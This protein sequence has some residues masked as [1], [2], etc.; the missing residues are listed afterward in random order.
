MSIPYE[1]IILGFKVN[2]HL[3]CEYLAFFLA[4]RLYVYLRA[5]HKDD[6]TSENRLSII[7]GAAVGAWLGSRIFGVLEDPRLIGE[8][9]WWQLLQAKTIMGGLF[10]GLIGV[11]LSKKIIGERR[12]SGD[13]FTLPIILG[14][15]IGRIGCFLSGVKDFTYG[16]PTSLWTGMNLGDGVLRHPLALYELLFLSLLFLVFWQLPKWKALPAG[17]LFQLFMLAYFGFRFFIEFLKP[18]T[19]LLLE[20]STI[21]WLCLLCWGYYWRVWT[22]RSPVS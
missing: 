17:R 13:L 6:I 2:I 12:S 4:Y 3:V 20:L 21:Q 19:F 14:I 7:L 8:S 10:G 5:Y 16:R 18:N 11:E 1:P 9:S 15:F 22:S